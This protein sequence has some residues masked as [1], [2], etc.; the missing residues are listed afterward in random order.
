MPAHSIQYNNLEDYFLIFNIWIGNNCLAWDETLE[1]AELLELTMVPTLYVGPWDVQVLKDIEVN[2]LNEDSTEGYVVRIFEGFHIRDF[3]R[4][5]AKW[6]R[7]DHVR[8]DE[9]WMNMKVVP[10]QLLR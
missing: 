5:V 1:W 8:S 7:H 10:N 2:S 9:H 3:S 4:S 6:V